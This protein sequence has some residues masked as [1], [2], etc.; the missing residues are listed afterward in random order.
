MLLA[1]IKHERSRSRTANYSTT[2][3]VLMRAKIIKQN[4]GADIDAKTFKVKFRVLK[5]DQEQVIKGSRTFSNNAK[6]FKEF[7]AW[8]QKKSVAGIALHFT[9]E[10]TG[11]YYENLAYFLEEKGANVHVVLPNQSQAFINSLNIKTRNDKIDA[12][13]LSIMGLERILPLWKPASTQMRLLKKLSRERL[14]LLR[15]KTMILN[16]LHAEQNSYDPCKDT[17]KRMRQLIKDIE[18][19]MKAV[20]NQLALETAKDEKLQNRINEICKVKG[21]RFITA[22]TVVAEMN[23]F[24]LFRNR[25]QVVSFVG[26]D[27]V[28]KQSGSSIQSKPKISKKGNSYIRRALH[29]PALTAV[30]HNEQYRQ[31]SDRIYDKTKIKMKGYVAVQR[32]LLLLIFTLFKSEVNYNDKH[33]L[34]LQKKHKSFEPKLET[35][36]LMAQVLE[37]IPNL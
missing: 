10:A 34:E 7:W 25:N 11:V 9:M 26:Y 28:E 21:I 4:V 15:M 2:K 29:F 3:F 24:I 17:L 20:E 12:D 30:R 1:R 36:P 6:G 18:N 31:L 37:L 16:Q 13:A 27:V 33:Y 14:R 23:G 22:I 32:K 8:V 35:N 5:S 19:K